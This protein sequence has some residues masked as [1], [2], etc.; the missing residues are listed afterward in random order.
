MNF[1]VGEGVISSVSENF[2]TTDTDTAG[3]FWRGK[4][5]IPGLTAETGILCVIG[6]PPRGTEGATASAG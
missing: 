1:S 6:P 3:Q 2:T 5:E 4:P